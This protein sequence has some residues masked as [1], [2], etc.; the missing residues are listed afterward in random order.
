ME[1]AGAFIEKGIKVVDLGADF[2]IENANNWSEWY[3]MEHTQP[4]LLSEAVYGLPE[5]RRDAVKSARLVANPGCYPTAVL[6]ALKPLMENNLIDCSNI[7]A[8]CKSG[9]SGAGRGANQATLFCE[10]T[11]AFKL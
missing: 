10:V 3:G 1:G 9:T 7:I 11:E 5:V 6:L 2:R 8:D 4:T